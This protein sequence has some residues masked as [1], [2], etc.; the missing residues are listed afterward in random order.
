[1]HLYFL[2]ILFFR[3]VCYLRVTKLR[4]LDLLQYVPQFL[5]ELNLLRLFLA[6]HISVPV[7][8]IH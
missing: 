3:I 4:C 8:M 7:W 2:L 1:M 5:V 6:A